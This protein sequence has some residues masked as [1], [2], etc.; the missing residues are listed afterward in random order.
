MTATPASSSP[1]RPITV[2]ALLLVAVTLVVSKALGQPM[3][4]VLPGLVLM[5][6]AAVAL[7][8]TRRRW[9][10]ELGVLAATVEVLVLVR[11]DLASLVRFGD[12]SSTVLVVAT[13]VRLLASL[14]ALA[15]S[16]HFLLS[17]R[18]RS[19]DGMASEGRP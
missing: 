1:A 16:L 4:F 10:A 19:L 3:E 13:W 6:A 18:G 9:A 7:L 17:H 11:Q 2:T 5:T 14:V 8:R 15:G 12:D